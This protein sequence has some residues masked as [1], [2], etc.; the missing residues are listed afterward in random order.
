M[1]KSVMKKWIKALKSGKY[2]KT[3]GNLKNE[4]G[5]CCLGVLCAI[6]P[7]KNN[8]TKMS[9]NSA[10]CNSVLPTKVQEFAG[11]KSENGTID[12][13]I[14]LSSMNDNGNSFETIAD[15]IEQN[16]RKL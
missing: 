1:K 8:Y 16:W 3:T 6:S 15:F 5:H 2:K 14:C 4:N 10:I 7:Y 11:M 9:W 13:S 12:D